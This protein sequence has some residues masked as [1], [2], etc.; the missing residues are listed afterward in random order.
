M[1]IL[2]AKT[3]IMK[4]YETQR[5]ILR[6]F[7]PAVRQRLEKKGEA[8]MTSFFWKQQLPGVIELSGSVFGLFHRYASADFPALATG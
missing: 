8:E 1:V 5:L 2:E 4:Q 3:R 6:E 7:N